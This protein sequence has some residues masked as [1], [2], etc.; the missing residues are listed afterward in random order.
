MVDNFEWM[1]YYWERGIEESILKFVEDLFTKCYKL[2]G[3]QFFRM[4]VSDPWQV[5]IWVVQHEASACRRRLRWSCN[6]VLCKYFFSLFVLFQMRE[7]EANRNLF[8]EST[9]KLLVT[10][11]DRQTYHIL[12]PLF[13]CRSLYLHCFFI[14]M[15]C[16]YY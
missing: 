16:F 6:R 3:L 2:N 13:S 9:M 12:V 1:L 11:Q 14:Y 15:K 7:E 10:T 5:P 4:R 8:S